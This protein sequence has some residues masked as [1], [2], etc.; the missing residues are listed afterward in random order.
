VDDASATYSLQRIFPL[1][2]AQHA[3]AGKVAILSALKVGCA[4]L[5]LKSM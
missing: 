5:M 3:L 4:M 1:L 2:H